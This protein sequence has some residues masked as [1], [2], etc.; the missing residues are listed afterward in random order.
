VFRIGKDALRAFANG[1][2][3]TVPSLVFGRHDGLPSL[4]CTGG[5]QPS[6]WRSHDGTLW[7][8]TVGGVAYISPARLAAN[9]SPTSVIVENVIVDGESQPIPAN[10]REGHTAD[11]TKAGGLEIPA[12]GKHLEFQYTGLCFASPDQVRFRYKLEGL[13]KTWNDVGPRRF[14]QYS[15]LPPGSYRFLVSACNSDGVWNETGA[16]LTIKVLPYFWETWWFIGVFGMAALG[17]IAVAVHRL[18]T[19]GLRRKLQ[20]LERQRAIQEDRARI[21]RDIHDDLGAGLTQITLFSELLRRAPPDRV[22]EHVQQIS[23]TA[24]ALTRAM[25]ETVWALNPK[26]D[27]L[28][29]LISYICSFAQ[30]Y[31]RSAH[32]KCRLDIPAQL[33]LAPISS[34]LR[35]NLYV[36]TKEALNNVLKHAGA[37][38]VWIRLQLDRETFTLTIEDDGCGMR[39]DEPGGANRSRLSSGHGLNNLKSRMAAVGG[40]CRIAAG[41]GG[42]GIRI[43]LQVPFRKEPPADG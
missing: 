29:S 5:Y 25:D 14:A 36:S 4:E 7:F 22:G 43:A 26:N 13:E 41:S 19:R 37:A 15:F 24:H 8:A 34:E 18:S 28:E 11:R 17:T 30:E 6:A 9:S 1:E 2:I 35:H 33:P 32:V 27:T 3:S 20:G 10:A 38:E 31:L 23:E 40:E 12:G 42:R 16:A 21:A 39:S